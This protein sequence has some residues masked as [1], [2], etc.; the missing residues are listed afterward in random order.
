[1]EE[2][3][4]WVR[5]YKNKYIVSDKGRI[6]SYESKK[7]LSLTPRSDGYVQISFYKN[8]EPNQQLV[9]NVVL[10]SFVGPRPPGKEC[11]HF[12]DTTRHNNNLTN[13]QW[14]TH[15]INEQDKNNVLNDD[16]VIA[17]KNRLI[18]VKNY[19]QVAKEFC[20]LKETVSQLAREKTYKGIG[21]D[22]SNHNFDNRH[23][24]TES[25]RENIRNMLANGERAVIIAKKHKISNA[26]VYRI[27]NNEMSY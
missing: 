19:I 24:L 15:I 1:M 16:T 23:I 7:Y 6:Y 21:P 10:D 13:L 2:K 4:S 5:N 18:E 9:H 20:I 26:Q 11:R 14:D 25:E 17:I 3:W 8:G 12:P 27:K 22:I